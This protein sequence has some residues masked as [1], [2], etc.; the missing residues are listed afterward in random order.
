[1]VLVNSVTHSQADGM[2]ASCGREKRTSY[3]CLIE[4][5]KWNGLAPDNRRVKNAR[6][7]CP[8][9]EGL[10]WRCPTVKKTVPQI[11]RTRPR[12]RDEPGRPT[13]Q[14]ESL[15]CAKRIGDIVT[16]RP[17]FLCRVIGDDRLVLEI[18]AICV[19]LGG[20]MAWPL[21]LE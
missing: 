14:L 17:P 15:M 19:G 1:M 10:F 16:S 5:S 13:H 2:D 6:S 12:R 9:V 3:P 18:D 11:S 8:R 7:L 4:A 21:C 20:S